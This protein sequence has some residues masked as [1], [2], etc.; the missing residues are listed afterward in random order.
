VKRA[1]LSALITKNEE[2]FLGECLRSL[3]GVADDVVVVDTG[4][5]DRTRLML[6]VPIAIL[7]V[8]VLL[9]LTFASV[10][11]ALLDSRNESQSVRF[12]RFHR[13]VR[14]AMLNGVILVS[15]INQMRAAGYPA[16]EAVLGGG[17]IPDLFNVCA[18]V[19]Q[20]GT[21]FGVCNS[22]ALGA[23]GGTKQ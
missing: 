18:F 5:T 17:E 1:F 15:S 11:Q 7:L 12:H 23:F 6:I 4:S 16:K 9:Y 14:C 22:C 8:F 19:Q 2:Q 21:G 3:K 13:A 10:K 20:E